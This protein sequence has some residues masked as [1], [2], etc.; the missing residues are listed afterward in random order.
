MTLVASSPFDLCLMLCSFQFVTFLEI[1]I[2]GYRKKHCLLAL[3]TIHIPYTSG[4]KCV[5]CEALIANIV[6]SSRS[7]LTVKFL[8]FKSGNLIPENIPHGF[9]AVLYWEEG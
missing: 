6:V 7:K 8:P 5:L 4:G 1:H 2:F 3:S 9:H